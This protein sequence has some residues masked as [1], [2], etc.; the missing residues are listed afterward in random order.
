MIKEGVTNMFG[1]GKQV[2]SIS[3][4]EID[5]LIGKV[6]IIDVREKYECAQGMLKSTKNIPMNKLMS[7]ADKLIKKDET[8][9]LICHT[10]S[11]SSRVCKYLDK[12]GFK[13]INIKGGMMS[14]P[15]NKIKR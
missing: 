13:V 12:L 14:Y 15:G 10:G 1:F 8:Y 2:E 6:N 11:R 4:R 5:T 9:Y 7:D 3:A